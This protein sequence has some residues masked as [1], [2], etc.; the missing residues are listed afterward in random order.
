MTNAGRAEG[1]HDNETLSQV[2]DDSRTIAG[3]DAVTRD[4]RR[5]KNQA[6]AERRRRAQERYRATGGRN[7]EPAFRQVDGV[8]VANNPKANI[9]GAI[10]QLDQEEET[11]ANKRAKVILREAL[12][13]I[14]AL[15]ARPSMMDDRDHASTRDA[16]GRSRDTRDRRLERHGG[17]YSQHHQE[18]PLQ[19]GNRQEQVGDNGDLRNRLRNDRDAREVISNRRREREEQD[20]RYREYERRNFDRYDAY[21]GFPAITYAIRE[22]ACPAK[23]KP[24]NIDKFDGK[25]DPGQWLRLYST[26]VQAAGGNNDDKVNYFPVALTEGPLQWLQQ[27]P[28]DT[29]D[30]W[31][32]LTKLFTSTFHGNW[33]K[34]PPGL[35][36]LKTCKKKQNETIR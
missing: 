24:A 12:P 30:S 7:L 26:A 14:R 36:E 16:G 4:A 1:H 21:D 25:Q 18:R 23:F 32:T 35:T 6:R 3:E 22:K 10:L 15:N 9:Y 11:P 28:K 13:Q 31:E 29:I 27:L 5:R 33:E 20:A 19:H 8:P 2:S 17:N 34:P